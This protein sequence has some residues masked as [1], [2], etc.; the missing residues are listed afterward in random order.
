[1]TTTP[2]PLILIIDEI[3]PVVRL[4][5]LEMSVQGYATHSILI[6]ED[7]I[8]VAQDLRP[9]AIVLG[10]AYPSPV[11]F[12]V[13]ERLRQAVTTPI[14]FLAA[15]DSEGD[16]VLAL[17]LGAADVLMAPF[18]PSD[19]ALRLRALVDQSLPEAQV[20]TRGPLRIDPLRRIVW[21][22]DTKLVLATNEWSLL[23]TLVKATES[24]P[25]YRLLS[26]V[27]GDDYKEQSGFLRLWIERLRA[28]IGDD[29]SKP[30]IILGNL[31]EGFSLIR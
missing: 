30:A 8:A 24:V 10:S 21:Q 9:D 17:K 3:W 23:L 12:D 6:N 11:L 14:L 18:R 28:K 4:I 31:E 7:P 13:L 27:W 16:E 1:M 29:P 15:G 19:M 5:E 26:N 20:L 25:S 22:G 2:A